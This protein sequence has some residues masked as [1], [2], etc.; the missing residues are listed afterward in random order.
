MIQFEKIS[1][2]PA[3]LRNAYLDSLK[4]PQEHYLESQ[5]ETGQTWWIEGAAYVVVSNTHL[6]ELYVVPAEANRLEEIF[7]AALAV[8]GATSI[9]C[10]SYDTQLLYASL[11]KPTTIETVGLMFR[12][13]ADPSFH[14]RPDVSFRQSE[15]ADVDAILDFNDDF[16]ES[17]DEIQS[18][19]ALNGL[20]VL[21]KNRTTIGC[22]IGKPVI[23][24]RPDIDIG[25]LVAKE[26]RRNGYGG[27]IISFLKKHYLDQGL[28]PICGCS[29]DNIGSQKAL[30]QAGYV[31][32][33]R[34]LEISI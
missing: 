3:D 29:I 26:H 16:F 21:E 7:D 33:H 20:F 8:S 4:E 28:R 5:V 11:S 14:P 17:G 27:H 2:P 25:M 15:P 23:A 6:V 22:G 1:K 13:I 19:A 34:I 24:N 32:E 12:R 18:Y 30:R 10:K 31:S 9:L